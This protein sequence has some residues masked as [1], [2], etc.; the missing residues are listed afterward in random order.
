MKIKL[1][2]NRPKIVRNGPIEIFSS[3]EEGSESDDDDI[4]EISDDDEMSV[5][6]SDQDD[7][8]DKDDDVPLDLLAGSRSNSTDP[9]VS[10][11]DVD[12]P[13]LF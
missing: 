12:F 8:A 2:P 3:S 11:D 7:D 9:E 4:I 6:Q 13:F 5:D 1:R 10:G